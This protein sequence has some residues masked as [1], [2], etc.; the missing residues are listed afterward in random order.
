[1]NRLLALLG[2]P[3]GASAGCEDVGLERIPVPGL[4]AP[5]VDVASDSIT[6]ETPQ[7]DWSDVAVMREPSRGGVTVALIGPDAGVELA[8]EFL[9][10]HE[11]VDVVLLTPASHASE[12][13]L[14]D[15]A[16]LPDI[17]AL[18][19]RVAERSE[20]A[21]YPLL[22]PERDLPTID[23][24]KLTAEPR[25]PGAGYD[26]F[27]QETSDRQRRRGRRRGRGGRRGKK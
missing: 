22:S 10:R 23:L 4:D 11:S 8:A 12:I 14:G 26:Q 2:L 1:M 16:N 25:R 18:I 24:S 5:V 13:V 17:A 27:L 19:D 7:I 3:G 9:R 15:H 21:D 6:L 20:L